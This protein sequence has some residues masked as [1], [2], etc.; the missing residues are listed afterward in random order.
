MRLSR[1]PFYPLRLPPATALA[2]VLV[3]LGATWL[4][5]GAESL[6]RKAREK[7]DAG[8]VVPET[9]LAPLVAALQRTGSNGEASTLIDGIAALGRAGGNSPAAVKAYL[10]KA[11]PPALLRV[12]RGKFG[13]V[14]RGDALMALRDLDADEAAMREAIEIAR[15]DRSKERA[16]IHSRGELLESWLASRARS[17]VSVR[18]GLQPK[19]KA[20]EKRALAFLRERSVGVSPYSLT[21]AAMEA[22]TDVVEAL[23]DAGVPADSAPGPL[24]PLASAASLGCA[25]GEGSPEERLRTIDVLVKAGADPKAADELGNT[26]LLQSAHLCPLPVVKKL[27]E[28]GAPASPKPNAQGV[29]PLAMALTSGRWDVAEFLVASGARITAKQIDMVFFEKPTDPKVLALLKRAQGA[30]K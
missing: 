12:A 23:L 10:K 2:A 30:A 29:T 7:V 21:Q 8:T 13:W 27:V 18:A 24:S 5:A 19:D 22:R 25:A 26:I 4:E 15:A 16:Y 20:S 9:D 14:E 28:L 6:V 11:A 17:G 1:R 3:A